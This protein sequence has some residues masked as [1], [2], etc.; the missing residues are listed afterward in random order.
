LT[1]TLVGAI[2][3]YLGYTRIESALKSYNHVYTNLENRRAWWTALSLEEKQ[4]A[5]NI[6]VLITSTKEIHSQDLSSMEQ[7]IDAM[8]DKLYEKQQDKAEAVYTK[9]EE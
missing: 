8:L 9:A 7:E 1:T 4:D 5:K 2:T 6:D 3:A